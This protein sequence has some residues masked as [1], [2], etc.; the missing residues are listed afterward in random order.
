MRKIAQVGNSSYTLLLSVLCSTKHDNVSQKIYHFAFLH[1]KIASLNK[2]QQL[3]IFSWFLFFFFFCIMNKE[4]DFVVQ[5]SK[6][7]GIFLTCSKQAYHS[8]IFNLKNPTSFQSQ[9]PD[10]NFYFKFKICKNE[11]KNICNLVMLNSNSKLSQSVH[12]TEVVTLSVAER[13]VHLG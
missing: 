7:K 6:K 3:A 10:L 13:S 12:L 2:I 9:R 5:F 1:L 8:C 11:K 4:A